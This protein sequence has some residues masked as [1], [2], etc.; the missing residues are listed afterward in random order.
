M[1]S[2]GPLSRGFDR[3]D[4]EIDIS[5][6]SAMA[7]R[8]IVLIGHSD[9]SRA[10]RSK[11]RRNDFARSALISGTHSHRG[12]EVHFEFEGSHGGWLLLFPHHPQTD[13]A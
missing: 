11:D 1:Q 12:G 6:R 2:G 13:I 3:S 5:Y 4:K 10:R 7:Y 8:N 9:F